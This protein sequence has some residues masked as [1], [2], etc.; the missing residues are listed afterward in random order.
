MFCD[1]PP[2]PAG[3][4]A[5]HPLEL[6]FRSR[7]LSLLAEFHTGRG[8]L[9]I[10]VGRPR[11]GCPVSSASHFDPRSLAGRRTR[12][13][14]T[15]SLEVSICVSSFPDPLPMISRRCSLLSPSPNNV[16]VGFR[17]QPLYL[18]P[19]STAPEKVTYPAGDPIQRDPALLPFLSAMLF[20]QINLVIGERREKPFRTM[21]SPG[22]QQYPEG[23]RV[24]TCTTRSRTVL[25]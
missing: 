25:R 4:I 17:L 14:G 12:I 22:R 23:P 2:H 7:L 1:F 18:H 24:L 11:P 10:I 5:P 21:P 6:C 13:R 8:P 15:S 9:R 3:R 20:D 16:T 19:G